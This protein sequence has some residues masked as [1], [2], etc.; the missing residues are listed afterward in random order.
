MSWFRYVNLVSLFDF[1]LNSVPLTE[2]QHQKVHQPRSISCFCPLTFACFSALVI[3]WEA[4]KCTT[5]RQFLNK[6]I[7]KFPEHRRFTVAEYIDHLSGTED[8]IRDGGDQDFNSYWREWRCPIDDCEASFPTLNVLDQHLGS[9]YHDVNAFKC[10]NTDCDARF[11]CLSGLLQHVE[12]AE[13]CSENINSGTGCLGRLWLFL[14]Q[15][16]D[17]LPIG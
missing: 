2:H 1:S 12:N 15:K 11:S 16:F 4:G 14:L 8:R 13:S 5:N 3:H 9:P 17:M 7:L 10:P 6:L